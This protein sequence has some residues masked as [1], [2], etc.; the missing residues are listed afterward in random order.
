MSLDEIYPWLVSGIGGALGAGLLLLPKWGESLIQF[1]ASKMLERLKSDQSR[2]LERL[3]AEQ[4]RELEGV[5]AGQGRELEQLK[6]QLN[7][8]GDRGR[9][10]NEM[11]F[12]AIETVWKA[13]VKAWLSANTC[14]GSMIRIPDFARISDEDVNKLAVSSGFSER[15][16][17]LLLG[18]TDRQHE[19]VRLI[20]W[21]MADSAR[22]DIYQARLILREQRIFMQPELTAEFSNV[23]ERMSGVQIER[24]IALEHPGV[25]EQWEVST[26]WMKD[27][28]PV[29][30]DMAT[31]ANQRLFREEWDASRKR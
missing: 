17:G 24:Q 27:C 10:S 7:H 26:A 12:V 15:E 22:S 9:R 21:Q 16:Q 4:S 23:I 20:R 5:K 14:V 18:S 29:F 30:D 3:K 25:A 2:D 1:R 31:K 13:F 19:Y 11:E 8:V 28:V 6:A